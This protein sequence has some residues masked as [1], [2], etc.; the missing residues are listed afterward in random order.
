MPKKPSPKGRKSKSE[1]IAD[2]PVKTRTAQ[3][4]GAVK[5]GAVSFSFTKP[6]VDYKAQ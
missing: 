6:A 5:G 1:R 4:P 2:L 3:N